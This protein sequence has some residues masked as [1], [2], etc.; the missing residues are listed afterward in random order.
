MRIF[1]IPHFLIAMLF[2]VTS[3]RM[4]QRKNQFMLA[5]LTVVGVIFCWLFKQAGGHTSAF[6]AL[7]FYFYFLVHGF[8]DDAHFYKTYGDMPADGLVIHDR[9]IRV[10]Q[11]LLIGLL[12]SLFWPT[13]EHFSTIIYHYNDP[14]LSA[15]FPS[16]WPF[17]KKLFSMFGPMVAIALVALHRITR[18]IPD[19]WTGLWRT[20]RPILAVFLL[21]L[22]VLALAM[23]G[24]PGAFDIWVLNHFVVWYIFTIYLF[25]RRAQQQPQPTVAPSVSELGIWN[26]MRTTRRG[27]VT[28]HN[29]MAL[30]VA[31]MM[32]VSVYVY[33][34]KDSPFDWIV[35]KESFYYWTIL[36]VTWSWVPR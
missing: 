23:L 34:Q 15:V 7:V 17:A 35:G 13:Y 31:G 4:Q 3:R 22:G 2:L 8:R 16:N 14:V 21:S 32:C 24:G 25:N 1:G 36:H 11:L 10:L 27:F 28:L 12:L 9:V 33:G 5:G 20:H 18:N 26:W 29:V 6:A 19:G 30:V